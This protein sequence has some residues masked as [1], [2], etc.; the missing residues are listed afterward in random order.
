MRS[1]FYMVPYLCLSEPVQ[2][3]NTHLLK[4]KR[5]LVPHWV[6]GIGCGGPFGAI[7]FLGVSWQPDHFHLN[8]C[9]YILVREKLPRI[10]LERQ[11]DMIG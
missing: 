2:C 1:G 7:F 10:D 8:P 9:F 4:N 6:N 5:L 3:V 11:G